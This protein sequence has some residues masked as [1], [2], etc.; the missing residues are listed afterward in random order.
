MA[1]GRAPPPPPVHVVGAT[2]YVLARPA[3]AGAFD[4]LFV[5]EAGQ[6]AAA[7]YLA[8]ARAARTAAV[9]VGD[10]QQLD[11]PVTGAHPRG[12]DVSAL[13]A[14]AGRGVRAVAP[15]RGLFLGV[16]HRVPPAVAAFVSHSLYD[17]RLVASPLTAAHR[18]I[19]PSTPD[20]E[21]VGDAAAAAAAARPGGRA[22]LLAGRTAGLVFLPRDAVAVTPAAA[23]AAAPA[24]AGT[25][26]VSAAEVA[27]VAAVVAELAG[28]S[29]DL[30]G[31]RG[32]L[33][34]AHILVVAPYNAQVAAL[35]AALGGAARV[36]TV[37][38]FQGQQ[39]PVV[40]V[41]LCGVPDA[42]AAVA[43]AACSAPYPPEPADD[44]SAADGAGVAAAAAT[45]GGGSRRLARGAAAFV[46]NRQRLN[47]AI[48]RAQCLAVVVG[49]AGLA[50]PM[51]AASVEDVAAVSMFARLVEAGSVG[52]VG[53]ADG[54]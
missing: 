24:A 17:G 34:P 20:N 39:A 32:A 41:S 26:T 38:K 25:P 23:A 1:G 44:P 43:T 2:A 15:H 11:M 45:G 33:T 31:A 28:A 47:V 4:Y 6:V 53:E 36:G 16:T 21:D 5:D 50:T 54:V 46:L 19:L 7:H 14:A 37:D 27:A 29:Y 48:T 8:I 30:G 13:A 40:I 22:G 42:P 9:L 18:L 51:A 52:G 3:A 35:S 49:A 12:A 10:Q